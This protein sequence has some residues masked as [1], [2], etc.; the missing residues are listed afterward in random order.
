MDQIGSGRN[1]A[2]IFFV[3]ASTTTRLAPATLNR[4]RAAY[5]EI[6]ETPLSEDGCTK[7]PNSS[8]W[9]RSAS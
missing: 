8:V 6:P 1:R 3:A 7:L 2:V 9:V 5:R 4:D